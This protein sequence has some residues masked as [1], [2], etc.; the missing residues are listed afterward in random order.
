VLKPTGPSSAGA[1][2]QAKR[3]SHPLVR[4]EWGLERWLKK[5]PSAE[6]VRP[7]HCPY[8]GAASQPVGLSVVLQGHGVRSRQVRGPAT[9]EGP[10][11][12]RE[13]QVRRYRCRACGGSCTVAPWE[14]VARRLYS[15]TA[16]AWAL[17]LWALAGLGLGAV[18]QRVS[19]WATVGASTSGSWRTVRAWL[20]AVQQGR[21]L[22]KV[23]PSAPGLSAR[24]AAAHV[25]HV[26]TSYALPHCAA[27][28]LCVQAFWGAVRA[29]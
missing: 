20:A 16:V 22:S 23:R 17:A 25:A 28:P 5:L 4:S 9:P 2:E 3:A 21:L 11:L 19:P 24:Q 1:M 18:R 10:A 12:L 27:P 7:G 14:V 26:V 8:C 6:L 13:V 29:A 15:V